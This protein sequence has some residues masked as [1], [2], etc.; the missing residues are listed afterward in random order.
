MTKGIKLFLQSLSENF[1]HLSQ[2]PNGLQGHSETDRPD[3]AFPDSLGSKI[4]RLEEKIL[5]GDKGCYM[6]YVTFIL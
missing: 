5:L 3:S 6:H 4:A 2:K 1:I